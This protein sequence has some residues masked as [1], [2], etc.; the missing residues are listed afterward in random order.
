VHQS[1]L[2][3]EVLANVPVFVVENAKIAREMI[4]V[5]ALLVPR[6]R[7]LVATVA[8]RRPVFIASAPT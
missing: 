5:H 1:L 8:A 6:R 2:F 4:A 3:E 7:S